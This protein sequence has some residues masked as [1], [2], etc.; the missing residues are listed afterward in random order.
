MLLLGDSLFPY[1]GGT[2]HWSGKGVRFTALDSGDMPYESVLFER[3]TQ[4][5]ILL[6]DCVMPR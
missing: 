1:R 2:V 5:V 3:Y 6:D 4:Q